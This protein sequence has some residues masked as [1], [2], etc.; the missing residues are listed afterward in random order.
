[1]PPHHRRS[2]RHRLALDCQVVRARDFRLVAASSLD[3]STAG[4]LV[5]TTLP[6][7][8]GEDLVVSFRAPRS[9]RWIDTAAVVARVVH[10]RRPGDH[11]R[12]LGIAFDELG[13]EDRWE[14]FR[15]LQRI[16]PATPGRGNHARR[17][18]GLES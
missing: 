11:G 1:M 14:L 8:T 9:P 3:L 16:P 6:V 10:G 12:C 7:L 18:T 15:S 17:V 2:F 5:P 4:M 13:D